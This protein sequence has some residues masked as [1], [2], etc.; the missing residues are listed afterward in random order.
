MFVQYIAYYSIYP[1]T[2]ILS[3]LQ[4]SAKVPL[5]PLPTVLLLLGE[6]GCG[7]RAPLSLALVQRESGRDSKCEHGLLEL[8]K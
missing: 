2:L 6:I 1:C 7:L 3:T 5:Y 8:E 4:Y